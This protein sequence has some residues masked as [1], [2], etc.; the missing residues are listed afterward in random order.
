MGRGEAGGEDAWTPGRLSSPRLWPVRCPPGA[1]RPSRGEG[2]VSSLFPHRHAP[3]PPPPPLA[4]QQV[5]LLGSNPSRSHL[6]ASSE[7]LGK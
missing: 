7:G 1:D 2:G 5:Q 4:V 3:P 6:R